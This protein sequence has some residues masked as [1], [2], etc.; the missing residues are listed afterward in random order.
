M[1]SAC[2]G[3]TIN[4]VINNVL[5]TRIPVWTISYTITLVRSDIE[6][7]NYKGETAKKKQVLQEN[8]SRCGY[9]KSEVMFGF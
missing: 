6:L 1:T 7:I 9:T 8:E 5:F 4:N 3:V 2:S